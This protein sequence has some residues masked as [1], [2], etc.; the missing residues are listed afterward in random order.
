MRELSARTCG[1]RALAQ[2]RKRYLHTPQGGKAL[3][4]VMRGRTGDFEAS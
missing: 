2:A 4:H 1:E 3:A